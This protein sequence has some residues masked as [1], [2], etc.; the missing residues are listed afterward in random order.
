MKPSLDKSLFEEMFSY[1]GWTAVGSLGYSFKD[2]FSN[3]ILNGF[4]GTSINAARG[5][6]IQVNSA[7]TSFSTNFFMAISPQITKQYAAGNL[8]Q[9]QRLVYA[10]ARYSF[11]LMSLITIPVII[12]M[13]Y[14][15]G[16]WL[17]TVPDYTAS[18]LT[19]TLLSSLIYSFTN[20]TTTAIQ[21]T[22]NIKVFQI[23]VSIIMLLELPAAYAILRAG[24]TPPYALLPMI[25]TNSI[26]LVF[27]F[28]LLKQLVP[29]YSLRKYFLNTVLKCSFLFLI[30][31]VLS[32]YLNK[33]MPCGFMGFSLSVLCIIMVTAAVIFCFGLNK[34]ERLMVKK[35]VVSKCKR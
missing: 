8:D 2:Q 29:S 21:A 7:I 3:I 11:Y 5:L 35:F 27:R 15:L 9:S 13:D 25:V 33:L 22:G 23:G 31:F 18:F 17:D 19:I 30:C 34:A 28:C 24:F 20:S 14:I 4:F 32:F 26:A 10:G 1:A 12:N 16:L 6:A